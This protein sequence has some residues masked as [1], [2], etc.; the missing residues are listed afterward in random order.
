ML[1]VSEQHRGNLT[2]VSWGDYGAGRL[3]REHD[4][5]NLGRLLCWFTISQFE[6]ETRF[7]L[8]K[9]EVLE[10]RT[11]FDCRQFASDSSIMPLLIEK[12]GG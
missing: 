9:I 3:G 4:L 8:Q 11:D 5:P 1:R 6:L 12:N 2:R 10:I 7:F